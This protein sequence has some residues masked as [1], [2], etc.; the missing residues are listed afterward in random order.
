MD[1]EYSYPHYRC[2]DLAAMAMSE[3]EQDI[4]GPHPGIVGF[5]WQFGMKTYMNT[6]QHTSGQINKKSGLQ[7]S[8]VPERNARLVSVIP[9]GTATHMVPTLHPPLRPFGISPSARRVAERTGAWKAG[10]SQS[11]RGASR[12]WNER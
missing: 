11:R 1:V 8:V 10:E 6:L 5:A 7:G 4:I 12:A 9:I 2:S 3:N